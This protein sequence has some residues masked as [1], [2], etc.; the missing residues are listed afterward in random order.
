MKKKH[1]DTK[2]NT[3]LRPQSENYCDYMYTINYYLPD[4]LPFPPETEKPSHCIKKEEKT[5]YINNQHNTQRFN[6]DNDIIYTSQPADWIKVFKG[7]YA[8]KK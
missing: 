4:T 3:T 5:P 2:A 7:A 1:S 6:H 8:P